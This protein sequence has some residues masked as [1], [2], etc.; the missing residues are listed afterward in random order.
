MHLELCFSSRQFAF[1]SKQMISALHVSRNQ[2][3][4]TA[5]RRMFIPFVASRMPPD[6][7]ASWQKI[8]MQYFF[9]FLILASIFKLTP[10]IGLFFSLN[11]LL[12]LCTALDL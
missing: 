7:M 1:F 5:G 8:K 10:F 6:N 11:S 12:P 3:Q 2:C 9:F 4:R